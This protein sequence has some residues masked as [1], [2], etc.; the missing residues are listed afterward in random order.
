[1]QIK[2][3][4]GGLYLIVATHSRMVGIQR[5]PDE[6]AIFIHCQDPGSSTIASDHVNIRRQ[7]SRRVPWDLGSA[8]PLAR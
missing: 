8:A 3:Y 1:M 5:H 7:K 4:L 6:P 2:L